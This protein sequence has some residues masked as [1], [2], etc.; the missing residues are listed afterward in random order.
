MA[1]S[2]KHL[3]NS[4]PPGNDLI[5]ENA[6][7]MQQL[8]EANARYQT[9]QTLLVK[10]TRNL[11]VSSAS[12][13]A[14]VSSLLALDFFWD[15]STQHE[16]LTTID[17][18]VNKI[19][20]LI[21]VVTLAFRSETGTLEITPESHSLMEVLTA[22]SDRTTAQIPNIDIQIQP[23]EEGKPVVV[24]Y[25]HFI[26]ALLLLFEGLCQA[27]KDRN[28]FNI[29]ALESE[30]HWDLILDDLDKDAVTHVNE[31]VHR[32]ENSLSEI[33]GLVPEDVFKIF[34]ASQLL[35]LQNIPISPNKIDGEVTGLLLKIPA[36]IEKTK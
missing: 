6:T 25:E 12:I 20:N 4:T 7:L 18:S 33:N 2:K 8:R 29:R 22:L 14:A 15:E 23:P 9:L 1:E 34:V 24:D 3:E 36:Y 32:V 16:F 31:I 30:K 11:Q 35:K 27:N 5:K 28:V 17:D 26:T 13:K 21:S 19:S 10:V